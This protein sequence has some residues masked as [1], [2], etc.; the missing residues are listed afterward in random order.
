MT[1]SESSADEPE[2]LEPRAPHRFRMPSASEVGL[3]DPPEP[4]KH[5]RDIEPWLS[6][7]FQ[8]EHV[9]LL[10]GNGLTMGAARSV[11]AKPVDMSAVIFRGELEDLIGQAAR[12]SAERVGRGKG[13]LEDQLRAASELRAGLT[14]LR[15][16]KRRADV[17][18]AIEHALHDL[19]RAVL[20][21]ERAVASAYRAGDGKDVLGSFLLSFA[22]R[23]SSRE[24]LSLFTTNYDRLAEFACE[25]LGLRVLDRFVGTLSPVFRSSRLE[26]DLHYNPPGIR[27]EPRFLEGVVK[28]TKLHGSIDWRFDEQRVRRVPLPFGA[29][30]THPEATAGAIRSAGVI[31]PMAAK[32]LETSAFPYSELFRDF[33]AAVCRPNSVLVTYGYGFGDSHINAVINDMLTVPSTHLV[34]ISF[35]EADGRLQRF[36]D[37]AGHGA[38]VSYLIGSH[39]GNI[40]VLVDEYLPKPAIDRITERRAV[41]LQARSPRAQPDS[42]PDETE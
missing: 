34:I 11:G 4:G 38:Q 24:R 3:T 5:R 17:E 19:L 7:M 9:S 1:K 16:F 14:V 27:G 10:V 15:E 33:S 39:F 21:T 36:M 23:S 32:D 12:T 41:L 30:A 26:V 13:N 18:D 37:G 31:Y 40:E 2:P 35:D 25:R 6:A 29:D 42:G 20:E 28:M 22:A 8:S